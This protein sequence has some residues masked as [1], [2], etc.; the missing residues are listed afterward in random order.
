MMGIR[1]SL[2]H[3]LREGAP[4]DL[5]I[6]NLDEKY[7]IDK[8]TFFSKGKNTPFDGLEVYGKIEKT[9]VAGRFIYEER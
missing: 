5:V 3:I 1:L 2:I 7:Q 9:M 4:A 6:A 8:N